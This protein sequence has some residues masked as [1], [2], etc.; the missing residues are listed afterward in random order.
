ML[1]LTTLNPHSWM[2]TLQGGPRAWWWV[3]VDLAQDKCS[4]V[5]PLNRRPQRPGDTPGCLGRACLSEEDMA[6]L[7]RLTAAVEECGP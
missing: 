1:H 2:E 6:N 5:P 3:G 7:L 4:G